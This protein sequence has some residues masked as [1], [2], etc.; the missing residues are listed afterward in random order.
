MN[1]GGGAF[2]GISVVQEQHE[3]QYDNANPFSLVN[4]TNKTDKNTK[5]SISV[6]PI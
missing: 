2:G 1:A 3:H 4:N 6:S 5:S